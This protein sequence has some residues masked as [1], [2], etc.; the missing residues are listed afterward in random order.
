[1]VDLLGALDAWRVYRKVVADLHREAE[2]PA[3]VVALD[4]VDLY[5]E[6]EEVACVGELD[7]YARGQLELCDVFLKS[8]L[9]RTD[10]RV[11]GGAC[12]ARGPRF[13]LA[14]FLKLPEF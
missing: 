3:L 1:M 8:D 13:L 7:L 6:I 10:L 12:F 4:R 9:G 2:R 14:L 11:G 5:Q